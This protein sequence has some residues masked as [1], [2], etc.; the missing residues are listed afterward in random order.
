MT[1]QEYATIVAIGDAIRANP[2]SWDSIDSRMQSVVIEIMRPRPSFSPEQRAF[3]DRWWLAVEHTR[4]AAINAKLPANTIVTP[5]IDG[6]GGKWIS[7]DLFTDAVEPGMRLH[8]I[9]DDL[10]RLTLHYLE[11]DYWPVPDDEPI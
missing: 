4:L 9:L 3:L 5:R 11:D 6:D 1:E 10:L 7:A 8:A 2:V